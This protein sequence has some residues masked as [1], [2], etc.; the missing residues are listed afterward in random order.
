[1]KE[2]FDKLIQIIKD[3]QKIA[4][5]HH[6]NIDGDSL[7]CFYGLYLALKNTYPDKKYSLIGNKED[8]ER[9]LPFIKMDYTDFATD[10]DETWTAIVG[11]T[12]SDTMMYNYEVFKK[13]GKKICFDHHQ[14]QIKIEH[15][16]FWH[17]PSYGASA[18]QAYEI[19]EALKLKL[20]E[21][22][23]FHLMIGILTDT[24]SF[25][26]SLNDS[27]PP[28]YFSKYLEF[29]SKEK[30]DAYYQSFKMK[31]EDDIA[32]LRYIW[33][34]IKIN[35]KVAY[36]VWKESYVKKYSD[37]VMKKY[38]NTIGNIGDTKIWCFFSP[39]EKDGKPIWKLH[40]R[41]IGPNVAEYAIKNNGGGHIRAA[42]ASKPKNTKIKTILNELNAI[43]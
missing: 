33:K 27:K 8:I 26:F 9:M 29:I 19:V 5:F 43:A 12:S 25:A 36:V 11:D 35:G 42:G 30:M 16:V 6:N 7:S 18:L 10:I 22:A 37:A 23:A 15:D 17:V 31:N 41:S 21:E 13:A 4:L 3:S 1:M 38:I 28:L 20:D 24:G 39:M 34:N 32:M 14:N 2:Q 40:L